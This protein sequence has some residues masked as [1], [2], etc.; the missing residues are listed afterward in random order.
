MSATLTSYGEQLRAAGRKATLHGKEA[1]RMGREELLAMVG[2]QRHWMTYLIGGH[3][4]A[5]VTIGPTKFLDAGTAVQVPT[6]ANPC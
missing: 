5:A 6:S 1:G 2:W 3:A 4:K